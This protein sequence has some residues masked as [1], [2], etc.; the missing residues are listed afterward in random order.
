MQQDRNNGG[1]IYGIDVTSDGVL[2]LAREPVI[3][4]K[5]VKVIVLTNPSSQGI[6][7]ACKNSPDGTTNQAEVRKGIYLTADGGSYEFNETNM[8]ISE[9]WAIHEDTGEVHRL[10]VQVCR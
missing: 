3:G 5:A 1:P 2:V 4:R 8:C 7:V 9:I 10:C 6:F